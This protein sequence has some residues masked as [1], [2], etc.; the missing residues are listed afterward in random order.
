[1]KRERSEI[2]DFFFPVTG[3]HDRPRW[4]RYSVAV[5]CVT[6]GWAAREALTPALGPTALPFLTFFPA[7]AAAAWFGRLGP[8]LSAVVLSAT[9]AN[10]FFIE[11]IHT[12]SITSRYDVAAL[13]GFALAASF[14]VAAIEAMHR[15]RQKLGRARDLLATTLGSIGD[16]VIVA[17]TE[18]RVA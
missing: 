4:V 9:A 7:I 1:M 11:P 14:I 2:T 18:G 12:L 15:T 5:I 17:A 6:A 10:W 13:S 3:T 8:A 16:G